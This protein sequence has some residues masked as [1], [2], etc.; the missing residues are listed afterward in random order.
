MGKT[1]KRSDLH[2]K[3]VVNIGNGERLGF[4]SDVEINLCSGKVDA[5]VVPGKGKLFGLVG[6]GEDWVI[7]WE[8]IRSVGDDIILVDNVACGMTRSLRSWTNDR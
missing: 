8:A 7:P 3:E 5:I 4:V 6:K 2:C 1:C